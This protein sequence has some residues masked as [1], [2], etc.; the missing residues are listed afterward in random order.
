MTKISGCTLGWILTE[1]KYLIKL[2]IAGGLGYFSDALQ[3]KLGTIFISR[4]SGADIEN[5]V[6]AL[7]VGQTVMVFTSY[8]VIQGIATGMN[9]LCS[10]AY[11]A[12]N[13]KLMGTYFM[14]AMTIASLTCFPIW[15]IW[16]SV[17]PVIYY[18]TQ[19]SELAQGA[20]DYATV[21][22]FSYP[23]YIYSKLAC[24]F[25]QSQNIVYPSLAIQVSGNLFNCCLQYIFVVV[26][27]LEI[28]GAALAY[29]ISTFL[30]AILIFAYI[31]FT[32]VHLTY[33]LF[34]WSYLSRWYHFMEYGL[35]GVL[36]L[37]VSITS[38][39][40]VPVIF[41]GFIL[42]SNHQLALFGIFSV[43]WFLFSTAGFGFGIGAN[44]RIGN[45]LGDNNS[46]Q[47][48]KATVVFICAMSLIE[49]TLGIMII[50]FSH[51]TS[52]IFTSIPDFRLEIESGLKI[53]GV[54]VTTDV[55]FAIRGICN[56]CCLQMKVFIGQLFIMIVTTTLGCV[57]V[58]YVTWKAVGYYLFVA[59]GYCISFCYCLI[60]LSI[61][62][63][64]K[65]AK[66]VSQNTS[67]K[68]LYNKPLET[69]HQ[70]E[71]SN[72]SNC[73]NIALLMRYIILLLIGIVTFVVSSIIAI[74]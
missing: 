24:T 45:I 64:D 44:I 9:T 36:Q 54:L 16:I 40:L 69:T 26:M 19:D 41:I 63:W 18:I 8:V 21:L 13:Y 47:A 58:Y 66:R 28:K 29:V 74:S 50:S 68:H 23:A 14:R 17:R 56:A 39:R 27:H 38:C 15:A 53:V 33:S 10:Q 6:S 25:L 37:L 52:F 32:N 31:Q 61:S 20:G 70:Q 35:L 7:L 59:I 34:S 49:L 60:L 43:V 72:F 51:Y 5:K 62:N 2:G 73:G 65:I 57:L 22:C 42:R 48:K 55:F 12:T 3:L 67:E 71:E 30:I 46:S 4:T 1:L 11:G